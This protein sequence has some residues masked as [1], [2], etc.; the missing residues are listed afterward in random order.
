[1]DF[2]R[3][4]AG[5]LTLGGSEILRGANDALQGA[6]PP[7]PNSV[8]KPIDPNLIAQ[9][10]AV[11][12]NADQFQQ[13]LGDYKQ[14]QINQ[15]GE[16]GRQQLAQQINDLNTQANQRGLLYSGLRQGQEASTRAG[17]ANSTA[18]QASAINRRADQ[19]NMTMQGQ[20]V[21]AGLDLNAAQDERARNVYNLGLEQ[22]EQRGG[23]LKGIGGAVGS[24]AGMA[25]GSGKPSGGESSPGAYDSNYE[26]GNGIKGTKGYGSIYGGGSN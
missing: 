15:V 2:G 21:K 18:S 20:S 5:I 7:D 6:A 23:L 3:I 25:A 9:R 12:N 19:Q 14:G 16:Q 11:A 13:N 24:V 26:Q 10:N 22:Q 4:G 1:M 17:A 8:Y